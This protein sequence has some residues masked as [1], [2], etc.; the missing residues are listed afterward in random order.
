MLLGV[1]GSGWMLAS[2]TMV[3][4]F[5]ASED[6]PMRLA[7]VTTVEGA[8]AATGPIL[9]GLLVAVA[10]FVPLFVV[11]LGAMAI[12]LAVLAFRVREPRNR[13]VA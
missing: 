6:I 7:F 9:A 8:I 13:V 2:T 1:G 3:L 12:A 5:G 4:E 11:V 10:G